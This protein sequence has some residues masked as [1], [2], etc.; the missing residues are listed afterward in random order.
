MTACL[1]PSFPVAL[2]FPPFPPSSCSGGFSLEPWGGRGKTDGHEPPRSQQ[3]WRELGPASRVAQTGPLSPSSEL[4]RRLLPLPA[5]PFSPHLLVKGPVCHQLRK[6]F[7][8]LCLRPSTGRIYN[9][10]DIRDHLLSTDDARRLPCGELLSPPHPGEKTG[11][12]RGWIRRMQIQAVR[13]RPTCAPRSRGQGDAALNSGTGRATA[14]S[15]HRDTRSPPASLFPMINP[16]PVQTG[17]KQA[18]L[19]PVKIPNQVFL[20]PPIPE[21]G[22]ADIHQEFLVLGAGPMA[23]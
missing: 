10:N 13:P 3:E 19:F 20:W 11:A 4:L 17:R 6:A 7:S 23:K 1:L 18:F 15:G 12:Q 22:L 5:T 16:L 9:E 8:S 21:A 2:T 14:F